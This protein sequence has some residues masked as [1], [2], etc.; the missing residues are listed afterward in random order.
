MHFLQKRQYECW[1]LKCPLLEMQEWLA[2]HCTA[3]KSRVKQP[4][5]QLSQVLWPGT[6]CSNHYA[7]EQHSTGDIVAG[8][9]SWQ[10]H[11]KCWGHQ[12]V[13]SGQPEDHKVDIHIWHEKILSLQI[14]PLVLIPFLLHSRSCEDSWEYY[15]L[16]VMKLM[17]TVSRTLIDRSDEWHCKRPNLTLWC[18]KACY[19]LCGILLASAG[20]VEVLTPSNESWV[21]SN[22]WCTVQ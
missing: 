7:T 4:N 21:V 22:S 6:V 3:E 15:P 16:M 19:V 17:A 14:Q 20:F 2:L 8:K 18:L 10:L 1:Q 13:V 11:I 5:L 12:P 9:R